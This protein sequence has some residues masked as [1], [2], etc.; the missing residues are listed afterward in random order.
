MLLALDTE[1]HV[2]SNHAPIPP[3]VCTSYATSGDNVGILH[4][5]DP[6]HEQTIATALDE[7]TLIFANAPFDCAVYANRWD[8][9]VDK[10]FHAFKRG[11]IHDVLNREKL[12]FI[13]DGT[14]KL[15]SKSSDH[16]FSLGACMYRRFGIELTKD[17]WRLRYSELEQLPIEA[18][19]LPAVEYA[20]NDAASNWHLFANQEEAN[21]EFIEIEG[22]S[23]FED[24][25]RQNRAHFALHLMGTHG[26]MVDQEAV[27]KFRAGIDAQWEAAK[28]VLIKAGVVRRDGS[29]DTA[30][31]KKIMEAACARLGIEPKE[32]NGG[33]ISLD[34]EACER[35]CDP[36]LDAYQ[37]YGSLLKLKGTYIEPLE[38]AGDYP[39]H[40]YWNPIVDTGRISCKYP[41]LTNLPRAPGVR[42]C[43]VPRAGKRFVF[44]DYD[45]SEIVSWAQILHALFG[46]SKIGDAL[47]AGLDPHSM[48]AA[49]FLGCSYEEAHARYKAHEPLATEARQTSKPPNFMLM[50]GAGV[51]RYVLTQR[52]DM[53]RDAF[54]KAFP[55]ANPFE[56]G[57]RHKQVWMETWEPQAWFDYVKREVAKP[58][59]GAMRSYKS[60]R[61]SSGLGYSEYANRLFQQLTADYAKEALW[62]VTWEQF[63]EP[64]SPLYG[65]RCVVFVHDEIGLE[66]DINKAPA[67]AKRLE[68]VMVASS[69]RWCPDVRS[70]A[71]ARILPGGWTKG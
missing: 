37:E 23:L 25:P 66:A 44:C 39:I 42:E 18:W 15:V 47:N 19:P 56:D 5:N 34:A 71:S 2:V 24:E 36:L 13:A 64:E 12:R 31:A 62:D 58:G 32:T 46:G 4:V 70:G 63:M 53:E 10:V 54:A 50:G 49:T 65:T 6:D 8:N 1:T 38:R 22:C 52:K 40:P 35:V 30:A 16:P 68:E 3:L 27:K 45:K 51:E 29:R 67:A 33:G 61:V 48:M 17:D 14:F 11:S 55:S 26:I 43:Y 9:L 59:G 41:N 20:Q 60:H 57:A 7:H 69:T 28:T 21:R